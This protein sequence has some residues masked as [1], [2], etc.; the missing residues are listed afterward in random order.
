MEKQ[1]RLYKNEMLLMS[2]YQNRSKIKFK[3][4]LQGIIVQKFN[5]KKAKE[6]D[7]VCHLAGPAHKMNTLLRSFPTILF[8]SKSADTLFS[9]G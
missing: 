1:L 8:C 9:D 2:K 5:K 4:S 3:N 7:F 6:V